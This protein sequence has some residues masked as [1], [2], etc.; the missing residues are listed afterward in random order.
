MFQDRE[1]LERLLT[2]YEPKEFRS[3]IAI[4]GSDPWT[5]GSTTLSIGDLLFRDLPDSGIAIPTTLRS[6]HR[7]IM[8]ASM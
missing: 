5:A 4:P 7:L 1:R 6:R 3:Y 8:W 2:K